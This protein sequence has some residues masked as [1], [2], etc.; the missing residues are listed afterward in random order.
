M[1]AFLEEFEI[2]AREAVLNLHKKGYS[3]DFSGFC[4]DPR[5][6]MI[7]GDFQLEE[8]VIE[9]LR[10]VGVDVETNA[11]GYTR[12]QFS[13]VEAAMKK[14]K[15]QWKQVVSILPNKKERAA[16]SMTRKARDF[17]LNYSN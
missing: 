3:I 17:R 15:Q 14:I 7:E 11:S 10:E 12:L 6:Q 8:N 13:P 16:P 9:G 4:S 5:N 1:G 2:Q